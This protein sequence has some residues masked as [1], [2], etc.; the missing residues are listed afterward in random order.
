MATTMK[1]LEWVFEKTPRMG[2][3]TG[4]AFTNT[5]LGSG[6][7]PEALLAREAIQ[8]SCDA[9]SKQGQEKVKI[10]FRRVTLKGEEKRKFVDSARL[11]DISHRDR[12]LKLPSGNCLPTLNKA[13]EPLHLLYIEDF[14][15]HG[16]WGPP[17]EDT[18][19]F[20]KLLLS[21]GDPSKVDEESSG[22]SYG[23]GKS[24]YSANSRVKTF[25]AYSVFDKKLANDPSGVRLMGCA[26]LP[27]HRDGDAS[28]T[29]R[30]WLGKSE[31]SGEV[32]PIEE[33]AAQAHAKELGFTVRNTDQ[34]GTSILIVDCGIDTEKLRS[35]I[36]EWWWPRLVENDLDVMIYENHSRLDA[37]RPRKRKDLEPFI[38]GF[39]MATKVTQANPPYQKSADLN[40]LN[41]RELGAYGFEL[42]S[43][44]RLEDDAFKDK[45]GTIALIREPRMVVAY[46]QAHGSTSNVVGTFVADVSMNSLLR[47]SEPAN[48]DKWDP[49]SSRLDGYSEEDRNCVE[50]I[51]NRL[52]QQLRKFA[53]SA[54][55]AAP[56][57]EVRP[58]FLEKLL[59]N[60][61]K[62]TTS[63]GGK[64]MGSAADPVSIRF[65]V[66]PHIK[67]SDDHLRVAASMKVALT[68]ES[69][70]AI[71]K[72]KLDVRCL[73]Q[74]EDGVDNDEPIPVHLKIHNVDYVI[75]KE[76]PSLVEL[77]L[78]QDTPAQI[79]VESDEYNP[80]WTTQLRV[81]V[82]KD[83]E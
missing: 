60:L 53:S 32:H 42:I 36:E 50:A 52:K 12:A 83:A 80:D 34:T 30:A 43:Q 14:G 5:L 70:E 67:V 74:E 82:L 7:I 13:E 44:E 10:V 25:F 55:P 19:H 66:K 69:D 37:P 75:L 2:G 73:I 18:S 61:F 76:H 20:F 6:I 45:L 71:V 35:S 26:Y 62:P 24:V 40:R 65:T 79:D 78:D 68:P 47:I 9:K 49:N 81:Q 17:H 21:L 3:A 8:N 29:G 27:K 22:G 63:E 58:R 28:F 46:Y 11:V 4:T 33:D 15:T 31:H 57:S 72:V 48:H 59:G 1:K 51:G 77:T 39:E 56:Q 64:G 38:Q 41:G 54:M 16:L 23:F